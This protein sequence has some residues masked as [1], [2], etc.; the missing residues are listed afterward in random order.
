MYLVEEKPIKM[1]CF[2]SLNIA[3][4]YIEILTYSNFHPVFI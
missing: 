4:D 1:K 2:G 3:K